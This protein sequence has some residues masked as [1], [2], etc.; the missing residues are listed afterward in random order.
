[1]AA[2]Y[3]AA[4]RQ[5][6][7]CFCAGSHHTLWGLSC[8]GSSGAAPL[9]WLWPAIRSGASWVLDQIVLVSVAAK[10]LLSWR[11]LLEALAPQTSPDAYL[12]SLPIRR[13]ERYCRCFSVSLPEQFSFSSRSQRVPE[14]SKGDGRDFPWLLRIAMVAS[15]V[16][17]GSWA[18]EGRSAATD[19]ARS[20]FETPFF[21]DTPAGHHLWRRHADAAG[22]AAP[23][24]RKAF[25]RSWC[26][27]SC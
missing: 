21:A 18:F 3:P 15:S 25:R 17:V 16:E 23:F 22:S 11:R 6:V 2:G 19:C 7:R 9:G 5:S 8:C 20:V 24:C 4:S 13:I 1:M 27:M 10:L 12:L 14:L 26:G